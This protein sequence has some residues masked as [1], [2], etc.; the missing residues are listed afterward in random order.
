MTRVPPTPG[1]QDIP[2]PEPMIVRLAGSPRPDI[3][4]FL[5]VQRAWAPSLFP[6]GTHLAFRSDRSGRPQL[7][8]VDTQGAWPSQLTFGESVTGHAWSPGG[9]WILYASDRGGNER[10]GYRLITP[11]G[12]RERELL[13]PSEAFRVFGGFSPDGRRF[14]YAECP[15]GSDAFDIHVLDVETGA[16]RRVLAGRMGL[17]VAA[18]RPDGKAL[19]LTRTR[20]E[21]AEDLYLLDLG[22]GELQTLFEPPDP[23]RHDHVSWL[24]EGSGF[25]LVTD[26]GRDFAGL[27]FCRASGGALE[28]VETPERDVDAAAVT[29][30]GRY[31]AWTVNE[32]GYSR[33][34]V[35]DLSGQ[36]QIEVPALPA[37]VL[38]FVWADRVPEL[39]I[40]VTGP[41]IPGDIW[42]WN[43]QTGA[44]GRATHSSTAGL[45]P[46]RMAVPEP[47]RFDARDGV[48]LHGLL[49]LPN[50]ESQDTED[51]I[52]LPEAAA[53]A[54]GGAHRS[55]GPPPVLLAVHGGPTAQARPSFNPV[56]Q[57]LLARGIAVLD[58]NFRGSTGYGKTFARLDNLR[59]RPDAVR[60]ME[61]ALTW[62]DADGRTD[63]SRAAVMG[64]SYG[65]FMTLAALTTF[66]G[67]FRAGVA[68]VGVSNWI[69]ALEGASPQ[70]KA[71]DR[72]EYGDVDDPGDRAFFVELS[73]IT[74]VDRVRDPVMVLHGANDPRDPVT[75]SDQFVRAVRERGGEVEYLRFPDEGHGVRK[76]ENRVAAYRRVARFLERHLGAG[77]TGPD[78]LGPR[79][80]HVDR[81]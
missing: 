25:F 12:T 78:D 80:T 6:G 27:A 29:R 1:P 23:A 34:A 70:L 13:P 33:L 28:W 50:G 8:V 43:L 63:A 5:M 46:G 66:P 60:D 71:G 2:R 73:P 31:L 26:Q 62:L 24:P 75:E 56:H 54:S 38:S 22:T 39:A 15:P 36:D 59:R 14:A 19:V 53:G 20:G 42:T 74:H 9:E 64:G 69:T 11:D 4:R 17:Y 7:W 72:L 67:R 37:G 68:I 45:D 65:G 76:L 41:Q 77:V 40:A 35:R 52:V 3:L 79:E 18:W 57:Y 47:V 32:G 51:P 49:Y 16:G 58:L 55:A 10:E 30:D 61:D 21:D 81:G 44:F 48:T